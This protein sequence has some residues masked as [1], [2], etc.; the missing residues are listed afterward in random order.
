MGVA[1]NTSIVRNGL[2]LHLDAANVKSY[3]GSGTTWSDL[4]GNGNNGTLLN[5]VGYSSDNK[6]VMTFDG[7][8]DYVSINNLGLSDHTIEVWV[9]PQQSVGGTGGG[10]LASIIG[11]YTP[12]SGSLGK[13]T[14]IGPYATNSFTFRIDDG[15]SSHQLVGS[16]GY[17]VGEWY[18]AAMTYNASTG[19]CIAYLNGNS[20]GSRSFTTGI[21]FN[22]VPFN[23]ARSENGTHF[24]CYISSSKAYDRALTATEIKQNF[25][26]LRGRYGI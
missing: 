2:V 3:S 26:A 8:N 15:V 13:Y 21:V 5:S 23:I 6:G 17:T 10:D 4:S 25:E 14:Y 11:V 16:A 24:S 12:T 1:Y 19:L 22:S 18:Y 20:I 7:V 9:N